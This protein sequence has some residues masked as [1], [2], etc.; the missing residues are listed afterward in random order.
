[1]GLLM[2]GIRDLWRLSRGVDVGL[3]VALGRKRVTVCQ[4]VVSIPIRGSFNISIFTIFI[5]RF[6]CRGK[7]GSGVPPRNASKIRFKY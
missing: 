6:W 4:V 5:F 3:V 7:R 1:M 2:Y